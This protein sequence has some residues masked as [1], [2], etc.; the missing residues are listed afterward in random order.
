M[1][2]GAERAFLHCLG[3]VC[4]AERLEDV[5]ME[6]RLLLSRSRLGVLSALRVRVF[7]VGTTDRAA[8]AYGIQARV[9]IDVGPALA[10]AGYVSHRQPRLLREWNRVIVRER[11]QRESE[12][13]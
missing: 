12:G 4:W 9:T 8:P 2:R 5:A 10:A 13:S 11:L 6:L 7:A 3:I 1:P